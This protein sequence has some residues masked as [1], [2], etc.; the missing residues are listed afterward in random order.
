MFQGASAGQ[1]VNAVVDNQGTVLNYSTNTAGQ[2]GGHMMQQRTVMG[3]AGV[4]GNRPGQVQAGKPNQK[5][6]KVSAN[7]V[8]LPGGAAC[9]SLMGRQF[10]GLRH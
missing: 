4:Q 9:L 5:P 3:A 1:I 10:T 8:V 7:E 6:I 2:P